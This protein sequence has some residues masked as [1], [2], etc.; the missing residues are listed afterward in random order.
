M[1]KLKITIASE[2]Q[3]NKALQQFVEALPLVF[4]KEG[5]LVYDKRN[6]I[7]C[8]SPDASGDILSNVIVKQYKRPNLIQR[9]VYSFFRRSKAERSFRNAAELRNRGIDTPREIAF[10]EQWSGGLFNY[11]YYV[12][13]ADYAPPIYDRLTAPPEFDRTMASDFAAFAVELHVKGIL[14]HDLNSTNVLYHNCGD[15]FHFSVIDINRMRIFPAGK[16]PSRKD[17]LENLTRFTGQMDLFEY[18]LRCYA[19]KRGWDIES[20]VRNGRAAKIR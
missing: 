3:K 10:L 6:V 20:T 9:I 4:E 1:G 8:F 5:A 11:G 16:Q 13:D 14:H 7:K 17:C 12:S 2:Y 15:H 19:G 18:V